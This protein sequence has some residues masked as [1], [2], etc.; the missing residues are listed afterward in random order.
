MMRNRTVDSFTCQYGDTLQYF[1]YFTK[2]RTQ[3]KRRIVRENVLRCYEIFGDK[4]S[5]ARALPK[6]AKTLKAILNQID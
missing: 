4:E 6:A 3:E 5:L 1:V 2:E